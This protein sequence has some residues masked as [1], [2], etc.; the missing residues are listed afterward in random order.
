MLAVYKREMKSFFDGFTG[1]IS[2]AFFLLFA[3]IF[4]TV[5][6]LFVGNSSIEASYSVTVFVYLIAIPI[7]TMKIMS[8]EKRSGS[9]LLLRALPLR[10]RD[11]IL[12]KYFAVVTM[13]LIPS[14][15]IFSYTLILSLYG[16]VNVLAALF[17]TLALFLCGCALA[18]IG[19][20]ISSMTDSPVVSALLCFGAMLLVYFMPT[21]SML[22]PTSALGALAV[23]S[24]I[25]IAAA[26]IIYKLSSNETLA[27]SCGAVSEII[28]LAIYFITPEILEGSV[29]KVLSC[30]AVTS[31][32]EAFASSAILDLS[33]ILYF[34]TVSAVFV[35][36]AHEA[37][38]KA[39]LG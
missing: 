39:R 38:E 35:Y 29:A 19:L 15:V 28:L 4:V 30:L 21:L 37:S 10:T 13:I 27:L 33:S 32:F 2:T 24:I 5:T 16:K 18:A 3:G 11:Y 6:N 1:Y 12:G 34:I 36:F 23:F 20:F 31:R 7:L 17:G 25:I 22:L 8:E 9:F 26:F 14:A